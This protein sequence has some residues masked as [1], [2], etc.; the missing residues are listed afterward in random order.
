MFEDA[1]AQF[2]SGEYYT[3][4]DTLEEIWH[5]AWQGDRAFYQGIL[6][7]AVG[8]YHLQNHN[9]NGAMILLGEGTSRLPPYTPDYLSIDVQR[10]LEESITLL[11]AIQQSNQNYLLLSDQLQRGELALPKIYRLLC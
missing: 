7:I 9:Y 11:H 8:L 4:H 2:N 3:C 1:I 5:N 10:L 6:Q